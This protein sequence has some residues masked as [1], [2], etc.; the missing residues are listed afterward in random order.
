MPDDLVVVDEEG[1]AEGKAGIVEDAVLVSDVLLDVGKQRNVEWSKPSIG[2][3]IE[4]PSSMDKVRVDGA[5]DH[6]AV[7]LLELGSLVAELHD[8]GGA[9]EGEI[10]RVEEEEQPLALE[11]I[12][13]DFLELVGCAE[14]GLGLEVGSNLADSSTDH[15]RRH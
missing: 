12:E 10:Q 13:G 2:T 1:A 8:F 3:I 4:R 5:S 11:V 15:L 9:D 6:L 7:V 14:P